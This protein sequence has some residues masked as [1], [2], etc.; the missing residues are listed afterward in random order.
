MKLK[1]IAGYLTYVSQ[2]SMSENL[3]TGHKFIKLYRDID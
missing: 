1:S 3:Q 2:G